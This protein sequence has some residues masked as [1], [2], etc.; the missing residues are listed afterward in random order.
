MQ[1]GSQHSPQAIPRREHSHH[2]SF[3]RITTQIGEERRPSIGDS[4][5]DLNHSHHRFI[6][7]PSRDK[8]C[9]IQAILFIL[10]LQAIDGVG[11]LDRWRKLFET[12]WGISYSRCGTHSKLGVHVNCWILLPSFISLAFDPILRAQNHIWPTLRWPT[13]RPWTYLFGTRD[14]IT[15]RSILLIPNG[16]SF[17]IGSSSQTMEAQDKHCHL[18]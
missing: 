13:S 10:H 14:T 9:F 3:H 18:H 7:T 17:P 1:S 2:N 8:I 11:D 16:E 15:P 4:R 5:S 6:C 12:G